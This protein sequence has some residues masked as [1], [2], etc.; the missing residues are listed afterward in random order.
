METMWIWGALGLALLAAEMATGTIYLLWF[1]ISALC[2]A[3]AVWAYPNLHY[4]I[5]FAMYAL[6]SVTA[7]VIWKRYYKKT[8]THSRVGQSQ[9]EE[10]GRIGTITQACGPTQNGVIQFTQG[11]M[12]SREWT[13]ISTVSL[14]VGQQAQVTAVE[15]N[16][17][18]VI[19]HS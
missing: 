18:R 12:G 1:G 6:L 16:M 19:A 13:A 11:V 3:V 5:Q 17:L 2:M 4:G 8:E 14:E 7:L 9:G 10:I 15:G